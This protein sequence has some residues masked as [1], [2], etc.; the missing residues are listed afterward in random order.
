MVLSITVRYV[1]HG[2]SM[3]VMYNHIRS[4]NSYRDEYDRQNRGMVEVF[5][6]DF[7]YAETRE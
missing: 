6:D 4:D 2:D 1:L 7:G 3:V 5:K